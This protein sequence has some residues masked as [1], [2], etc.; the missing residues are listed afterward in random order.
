MVVNVALVI[1]STECMHVICTIFWTDK[2]TDYF[3]NTF[4]RLA[5]WRKSG[6]FF[7]VGTKPSNTV[8]T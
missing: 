1:V 3:P 2:L 8:I 7:A 6:V 5:F 4:N